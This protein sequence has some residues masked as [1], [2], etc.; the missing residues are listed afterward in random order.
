MPQGMNFAY[1]CKEPP[2]PLGRSVAIIGAGP[3]GLAATGYLACQG[4][5][6]H[7]YDK[8]PKPGGLMV[9]GI[10][11]HRIPEERVAKGVEVLER[12][13]GV[14]LHM[15]TKI[16]GTKALHEDTGDHFTEDMVSLGELT[17]DNDAVMICTGT[18]SSRKL[19]IPG[20]QLPGVF[21]GL[22]YLFPIR[23]LQYNVKDVQPLDVKDKRVAVVG[24]GHSAVDVVH[25]ALASGAATVYMLY[26]RTRKEAP[27][28]TFEIDQ[29]VKSG[30]VWKDLVTPTRI[31][32]QDKV[33]GIELL[34]CRLGEPD[35]TGRACPIPDE[36]S[37][38][39]LPVDFVVAAIGEV[40]TLPFANELGLDKLRKDDV[41]WLQMTSMDGV[42]VAGDA[43]TGPSKIGKA[44]Y[45]GMRAAR[46]LTHWL[47]L[48]AQ[49]RTADY[50]YDQDFIE[51]GA[52]I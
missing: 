6:V 24:A 44:I 16:C 8:L 20:E 34:Q 23:A 5:E 47:D 41:H 50:D 45:S 35:E 40:P 30:A 31:I 46:S 4:Y 11:G 51:P 42:F 15:R 14:K 32:G 27:C 10:P 48:Q 52:L 29:L 28:G 39:V 17:N 12:R 25:S 22:Q 21:S 13:Y 49:N 43:L 18:W 38:H 9:F 26:R 2:Q 7:L 1:L 36:G 19:R 37:R 3:S 33:E